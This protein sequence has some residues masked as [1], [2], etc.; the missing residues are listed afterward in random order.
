MIEYKSEIHPN[1]KRPGDVAWAAGFRISDPPSKIVRNMPPTHI[2]FTHGG[3]TQKEENE[4]SRTYRYV[5]AIAPRTNAG[6]LLNK[7]TSLDNLRFFGSKT[8]AD[9]YYKNR[10]QDAL[11]EIDR[12][13]NSL[14]DL[15]T[16]ITAIL[17]ASN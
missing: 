15:E 17:Q 16:K 14:A 10:V 6:I 3:K 1:D 9:E 13:K 12:A 2:V 5:R 11:A 8:D 7:S 4:L